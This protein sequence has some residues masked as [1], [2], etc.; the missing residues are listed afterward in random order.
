MEKFD[1]VVRFED[2][3]TGLHGQVH[4]KDRHGQGRTNYTL[5]SV[6][7]ATFTKILHLLK[8]FL[9][10]WY[11]KYQHNT[12]RYERKIKNKTDMKYYVKFLFIA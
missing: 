2:L 4:C 11:R 5:I 12:S 8:H 6:S 3:D 7:I 9:V 1:T 10:A